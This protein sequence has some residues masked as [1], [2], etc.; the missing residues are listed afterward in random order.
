MNNMKH[1]K[2]IADTSKF[3]WVILDTG[4][5]KQQQIQLINITE[6]KAVLSIDKSAVPPGMSIIDYIEW[7]QETGIVVNSSF[8]RYNHGENNSSSI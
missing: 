5:A 2:I 1:T 3:K 4:K 7:I 8:K 6:N